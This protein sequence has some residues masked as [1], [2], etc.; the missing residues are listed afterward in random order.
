MWIVE[1]GILSFC[2]HL[3]LRWEG[4]GR[5]KQKKPF[6]AANRATH[7]SFFCS[8]SRTESFHGIQNIFHSFPPLRLFFACS[9]ET[10]VRM[11]A[12]QHFTENQVICVNAL[13]IAI[14]QFAWHSSRSY[15]V[16]CWSAENGKPFDCFDGKS[17]PV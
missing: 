12:L 4:R 2:I 3:H 15:I 16:G 13:A 5:E 8:Q 7:S 17:A 11:R 14:M 6:C 9:M 1:R 10:M